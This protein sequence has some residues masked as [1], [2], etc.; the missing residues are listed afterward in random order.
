MRVA[1]FLASFPAVSE[2]FILRQ[3]TG[4]LDLGHEVDIYAEWPAEGD[5]VHQEV[6]KY[7]LLGRTV[8]TGPRLPPASGYWE[9]PVWPLTGETWLPGAEKP[10]ANARRALQALPALCRCFLTAPRLTLEVLDRR[11]YGFQAESL[12]ALYRLSVL[13][14]RRKKYDVLQA[15][16]GPVGR[17]FRF[18]R[19]LWKAPLIV[20]FH[21]YDFCRVP[22]DEGQGVYTR[23][24]QTADVV[25]VNSAYTGDRVEELG[26]PRAKVC[27]LAMGVNPDAFPFHERTR[28]PGEPVRALTV[29]RLAEKKGLEYSIR[30]VA[31]LRQAHPELHYDIAGEGPLRPALHALIE[32]LGAGRH[33]TL[34]GACDGNSVAQLMARAHLFLLTSVTAADG[35]QEGTPVSL[36][37]AQASGLPVLST[38]HSGIPEVVLDGQSGLL[39]P[40]RD[41][42]AVSGRLGYLLDH[43]ESWPVFGRAGRR[44]I[45]EHYDVRK[46]NGQLVEIYRAAVKNYNAKTDAPHTGLRRRPH[47]RILEQVPASQ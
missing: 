27:K 3:I 11:A 17:T 28:R 22:R 9:M 37:E 40:E 20:T 2:T 19:D 5:C 1:F 16:F 12:S 26:C 39:V 8:Y 41:V 33:V 31:E 35:D 30:A 29:A 15:H 32:R 7:D 13:A 47:R 42:A 36:M 24:F 38:L 45:E 44:H 34:H 10:I 4:L 14:A 23:L 18:V 6:T 25:T 46:L 21:G 43:P